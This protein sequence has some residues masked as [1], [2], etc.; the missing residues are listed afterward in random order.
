MRLHPLNLVIFASFLWLFRAGMDTFVL[1]V[2]FLNAQWE[3]CHIT[4]GFFE[5]ANTIGSAM[6]LQVNDVL[7]KHGFITWVIAYV[8]DEGGNLSTMTTTL[9]SMVSCQ[10]LG[11]TT[12]FCG[13]MLGAGH[14]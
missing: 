3:P 11:L 4:V 14:V 13:G 10:A 9:T 12:P 5:I 1:I 6:A 2:H 8:K 7:A